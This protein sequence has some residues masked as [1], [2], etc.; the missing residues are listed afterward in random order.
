MSSSIVHTPTE[1][2]A[3]IRNR[4]TR[5]GLTQVDLAGVARVTPRL[6]G[7]IENGKGTAQLEGVLRVLSAL[8]LDIHLRPR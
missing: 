4:R 6:V 8:G 3:R 5:L 2:G 7:E 1:I